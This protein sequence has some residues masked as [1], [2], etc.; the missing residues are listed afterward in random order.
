MAPRGNNAASRGVPRKPEER[1][2]CVSPMAY[3]KCSSEG[4]TKYAQKRGVCWT[5]GAKGEMEQC[6]F[7]GCNNYVQKGGVCITHG[8]KGEV[9][10]CSFDRC[11]NIVVRGGVCVTHGATVKHCS[12]ED[13]NSH[14]K[15]KGGVCYRHCLKG[16]KSNN[17]LTLQP[18]ADV[19]HVILS[20]EE[21]EL[22]SWIRKVV[23]CRDMV[24]RNAILALT[25]VLISIYV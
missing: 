14:A 18:N 11:S 15:M 4:C 7:E 24:H 13:C 20:S 17:N 3:K 8:A 23:I 2:E 10:R 25:V 9:K 21:E 19:T 5:H 1:W 12:F 22:N 16:I 6:N